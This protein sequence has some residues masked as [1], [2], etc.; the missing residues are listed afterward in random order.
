V[1]KQF[2]EIVDSARPLLE[3]NDPFIKLETLKLMAALSGVIVAPEVRLQDPKAEYASRYLREVVVGRL[4]VNSATRR[5]INRRQFLKREIAKMLASGVNP[6][7][8]L[9]F[10]KELAESLRN[11]KRMPI[12]ERI[13]AGTES[14]AAV[15]VVPAAPVDPEVIR[16]AVANAKR[17][18]AQY[19]GETR[20][21][22]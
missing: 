6:E 1:K 10:Q 3:S 5:K 14:T 9:A 22:Q 11:R 4:V 7:R 12:T 2:Q 20:D 15:P 17:Y 16:A 21:E 18:L 13:V 19:N 8:L